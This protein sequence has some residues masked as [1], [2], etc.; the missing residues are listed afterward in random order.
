MAGEVTVRP[1]T[2]AEPIACR[3]LAAY[4]TGLE[5][6][7]IADRLDDQA[8][9]TAAL[10]AVGAARRPAVRQL[11]LG[12][13]LGPECRE[14]TVAVLRAVEGAHAHQTRITPVWTTPGD[15]A[16]Y[17]HLTTSVRHYVAGA[18]ESLVCAT[19]NFQRSSALWTAL[20]E[21]T[22][23]PEVAVRIY[24]DTAAA[25]DDPAPWKPTTGEV[26]RT[27]R[28]AAVFRTRRLADGPVRTH[29]KFVAVDHQVL[30]VTS[31]N[32]SQSAE[33]RNV[34]LGLVVEDPILTQQVEG[35]MRGLEKA[36]YERVRP[37]AHPWP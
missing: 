12:A 16:Q 1:A 32:F 2:A 19:Y 29:A 33:L 17:G 10:Q 15:L 34:E 5:A 13:G 9:L 28:G 20:A 30:V 8:T 26:A 35:Q 18:R 22:A 21:A 37:P 27:M 11:L 25:D 23:R 7:E 4:L 6:K 31:A 3:A 14:T 36:L 24:L